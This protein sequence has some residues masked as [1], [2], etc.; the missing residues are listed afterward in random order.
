MVEQEGAHA[1]FVLNRQK[2]VFQLIIG[3][4]PTN[5]AKHFRR[6]MAKKVPLTHYTGDVH[7]VIGTA[8]MIGDEVICE[9]T[10][11]EFVEKMK[12]VKTDFLSIDTDQP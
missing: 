6:I 12:L 10:D 4:L 2:M 5:L 7:Q 8:E 1:S 3:T 11:P 9:I